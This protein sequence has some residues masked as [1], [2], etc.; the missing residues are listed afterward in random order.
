[1]QSKKSEIWVGIFLLLALVAALFL[2][3]RVANLKSFGTEPTWKL[4]ATFDNIGGLKVNSPV[5]I[6]GV[7][8]GRVTSI[9]LDDSTL[10]PKVTMAIDDTYAGKIPDTSS[11]AVRTQGLLGEQFLALNL[12]FNDP[13][14]G[15]AILKNGDTL[16]DTKSAMVLEDLIGQFLY[17]NGNGSSNKDQN[18]SSDSNAPS[19]PAPIH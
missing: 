10:S 1:M 2:C 13:D 7:V 11:L 14:L 15:S 17:K 18:A 3:M 5:K 19:A 6:G 12:G 9:S 16:R 8:I 4:Y